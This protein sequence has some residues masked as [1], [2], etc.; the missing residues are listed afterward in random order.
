MS[1]STAFSESVLGS[2]AALFREHKVQLEQK[3]FSIGMEL[4][5]GI[6]VQAGMCLIIWRIV[7]HLRL[8]LL[9][10]EQVYSTLNGNNIKSGYIGKIYA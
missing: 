10:L 8:R 6:T 3:V 7:Y 2:A 4:S 5:D 9:A 1:R